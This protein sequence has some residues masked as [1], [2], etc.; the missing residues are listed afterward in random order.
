MGEVAI[1]CE[2]RGHLWELTAG[3]GDLAQ[4]PLLEWF[5]TGGPPNPTELVGLMRAMLSARPDRSSAPLNMLLE[6][7]WIRRHSLAAAFPKELGFARSHWAASSLR[8]GSRTRR[9]RCFVVQGSSVN[10]YFLPVSLMSGGG[11]GV[12]GRTHQQTSGEG[13]GD[14]GSSLRIGSGDGGMA[15][16]GP[17]LWHVSVVCPSGPAPCIS[18][19][20]LL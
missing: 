18:A 20:P 1:A 14:G 6:W 2:T 11:L 3:C 17:P 5:Q 8:V 4:G 13:V 16:G 9:S 12:E 19:Q 10:P 7:G 15:L